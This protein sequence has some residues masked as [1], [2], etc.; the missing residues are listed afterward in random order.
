MKK[1]RYLAMFALAPA[2]SQCNNGG[3]APQPPAPPPAPT[4]TWDVAGFCDD[5]IGVEITNTGTGTLWIEGDTQATPPGDTVDIG[6]PADPSDES[7]PADTMTVVYH[8]DSETGPVV[9]TE[10]YDLT[11]VCGP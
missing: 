4:Y 10:T 5:D 1:I 2:L 3:C 11:D 7:E 6:W 9:S 8:Q